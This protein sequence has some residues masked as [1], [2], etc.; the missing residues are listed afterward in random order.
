MYSQES[1][2]MMTPTPQ[3]RKLANDTVLTTASGATFTASKNWYAT[4]QSDMIVLE[5]PDRELAVALIENNE[6]TAQQAVEK[7]WKQFRHNFKYPIVQTVPDVAKDGWDELVQFVYDTPIS[8]LVTAIAR[9]KGEV[10]YIQLLD[11]TKGA[12]ERRM[13]QAMTVLTSFKVPGTKEESFAGRRAHRLDAKRIQEFAAFI[14]AAR[15]EC[16]VPGIAVGIVQD[17]TCVFEKGF[18]VRTLGSQ[19]PV[20]PET[21]FMI[22]STTKPLTSFMMAKLI[23]EGYFDWD[24]PITHL[25]PGF[26]LGNEAITKRLLMKHMVAANT[27]IPRQDVEFMFNYDKATP[28]MRLAEM[29]MMQPTTDFGETFQYSNGM[30]AAGGYIAAHSAHKTASLGDAYDSV[31]QTEVFEP[32]GMKSTTFD[33]NKVQ[34][35]NYASPHGQDLK[36]DY[37][38]LSISDERW[39]IS[40]RPAGGAWSTVQD[41]SRYI[42][43]ELN[44]GVNPD[45]TRVVSEANILKR[46]ELQ[47]KITDK[48]SYGLALMIEDGQGVQVIHHGGTT[49][50]FT[51]QM[52]FLPEHDIGLAILSNGRGASAFTEVVKRR[53]MELL[54]DGKPQAT[55]MLKLNIEN[56]KT[57]QHKMLEE[58]NFAPDA[59]WLEQFIGTYKHSSLGTV[60]I[61]QVGTET[62]LDAGEWKSTL[63]QKKERDGTLKLILTQ[64]PFAG[65][66]LL[67]RN[68]DALELVLEMPQQKYVFTQT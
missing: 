52:F 60:I 48:W 53:F 1:E 9:R 7:A 11:G 28:E 24:T 15:Q 58:V 51:S 3:E 18:G 16:K 27:G 67:L 57:A 34:R 22:G 4:T 56:C 62:I 13:A 14:E 21:L 65:L 49:L 42:L 30:V 64:A 25:M 47:T 39:V 32:I 59:A 35:S 2:K 26:K 45:G 33:F 29:A 46:R 8:Y 63:G 44:K 37:I 17:G 31:M 36:L 68:N 5:E 20:T 10:W 19:E 66:E 38:P 50:G 41:M 40:L 6:P 43:T 23:D 54:F 55:Q 61:R 12:I